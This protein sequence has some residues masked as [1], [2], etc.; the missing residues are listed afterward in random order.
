MNQYQ[1]SG[2]VV[3]VQHRKCT[4]EETNNGIN[5]ERIKNVI[6]VTNF[7]SVLRMVKR[8]T[9]ANDLISSREYSSTKNWIILQVEKHIHCLEI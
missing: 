2:N 6:S 1:S 9:F 5:A 7:V 4:T 8:A 3:A